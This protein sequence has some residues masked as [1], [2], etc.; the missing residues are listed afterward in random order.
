MFV[1]CQHCCYLR[2]ERC[3]RSDRGEDHF[4]PA[5]IYGT[6]EYTNPK[7]IQAFG[8]KWYL[9]PSRVSREIVVVSAACVC[10]CVCLSQAKTSVPSEYEA[11][12]APGS[13]LTSALIHKERRQ[14][15]LSNRSTA[16]I[17]MKG[18][19]SFSGLKNLS[20]LAI[21]PFFF[22]P[23]HIKTQQTGI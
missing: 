5:P 17:H 8:H 12:R 19:I 6:C 14:D 3:V 18:R 21:A 20:P 4:V 16:V 1:L 13:L 22:S 23:K 2:G 7:S 9:L 11:V 15:I 10:A